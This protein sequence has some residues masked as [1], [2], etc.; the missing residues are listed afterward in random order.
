MRILLTSFGSYGDLN[1]YLGIALALK[2]RGH[3]PVLAV[4]SAYRA[5]VE[6]AGL[7]FQPTR[8][9]GDPTDRALIAR[10]MD[11]VRGAEFLV[12]QAM[13]PHLRDMYDDLV[14]AARGADAVVSHP[15][16]FAAPILCEQRDL[17]WA[18]SVLAPLGFFSRY[19]PP[20]PVASPTVAALHRRWP[21]ATRPL[22]ALGQRIAGRWARPVADFR[23][24]LG[25]P[26][27]RNPLSSGQFSPHLNLG[28][29]SPLMADPQ[30]DW[31]ARTA[32][33]GR[34]RHDAIHGGLGEEVERFL[35]DGPPPVVFTLGSSAVGVPRAAH[36]Y[37]VSA[38]VARALGIRAI[39]LVGHTLD[40]L[41]VATSGDIL[42]A[43]WAPHSELFHRAAAIVHQGGAGTSHTAL[44]AGR[45]MLVVPFAYDQPDNAARLE[46]L[47][48]ARV[49]YPQ[50]Y[51]AARVRRTLQALLADEEAAILAQAAGATVGR[52]DGGLAAALA[53]EGL[54]RH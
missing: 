24:S 30:P 51:T 21:P 35:A 16:T 5:H 53:I 39:L 6:G 19:D 52:E 33:T 32:I 41:A 9:D 48:V 25:L 20:L 2:A 47:G 38:A 8:P 3:R 37:D 18:A 23:R 14:E 43:P 31:P 17:P 15:L 49:V 1:P 13:M 50:H 27:G 34:V 12:R 42:V 22:N 26:P 45:P 28:L 54:A 7:E 29:F 4:M 10:I 44:A 36:F 46:R 40:P 11:P